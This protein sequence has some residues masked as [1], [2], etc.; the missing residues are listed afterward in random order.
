MDI[1]TDNPMCC[2]FSW[3]QAMAAGL[4]SVPITVENRR[5]CSPLVA[6][7]WVAVVYCCNNHAVRTPVPTPM[8]MATSDLSSLDDSDVGGGG[9]G[10]GAC[11]NKSKYS[12]RMGVK[13]RDGD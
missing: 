2:K 3:A 12:C 7:A 9:G 10:N 5:C 11:S 13:H 4:L 1:A 8:S 6:V